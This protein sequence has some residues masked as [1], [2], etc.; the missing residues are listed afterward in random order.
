MR[1]VLLVLLAALLQQ[2][3]AV[4]QDYIRYY[5]SGSASSDWVRRPI[6]SVEAFASNPSKDF[7][8]TAVNAGTTS[9]TAFAQDAMHPGV[10]Q[11]SSAAGANSGYLWYTGLTT[12]LL[13]GDE[14]FEGGFRIVTLTNLTARL[15]F[16]D[17]TSVTAPVDGVLVTIPAT[18]VMVGQAIT[19]SSVTTTATNYTVSI[20]TWYRVKIV[21]APGGASA[22]FYL[23]SDAGALLWTD[24]ATGLPTGAGRQTG[25]GAIASE[26]AGAT[27]ALMVIDYMSV[28]YNSDRAR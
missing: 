17:A 19:N 3:G 18:G 26:S 25:A 1:R 7:V 9:S 4:A 13:G 21:V 23:F 11:M 20:N 27:A 2:H 15:G 8:G 10:T 24:T 14:V 22:T 16:L 12:F 6:I 28:S 5:P